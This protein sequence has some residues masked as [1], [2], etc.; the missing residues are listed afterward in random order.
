MNWIAY[1]VLANV[2][3]VFM[4]NVYR[5]GVYTDFW[6]ALPYII[7]PILIVQYGLFN[8]FRDAPSLFMAWAVLT[9]V[10]TLFR[11]ANNWYIG[12][13]FTFAIIAGVS[14]MLVGAFLIKG[15]G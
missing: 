7:V 9:V 1:S 6:S 14:L 13:P 15:V 12:E 11:V 2:G 10:N 5:R 4:E 8:S 3:I